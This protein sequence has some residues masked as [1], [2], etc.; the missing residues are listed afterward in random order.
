MTD[1]LSQDDLLA[2]VDRVVPETYLQPIKDVGPGYE[3]YQ[4]SAAVGARCS[5]AVQRFYEDGDI[6]MSH[7]GVLATVPVTFFR[8]DFSAGAVRVLAGTVVSCS[9]GG[10][11]FITQTDAVLGATDLEAP[12]VLARATGFGYEYN[13]RGPFAVASRDPLGPKT[14]P[15]L[16]SVTNLQ[17]F[18]PSVADRI[19]F[20]TP[21]GLKKGDTL[22]VV[23]GTQAGVAPTVTTQQWDTV[24]S[25]IGDDSD[26]VVI[27]TYQVSGT[28]DS[29]LTIDFN[30]DM[31]SA[32]LVACVLVYRNAQP[33][34]AGDVAV[35]PTSGPAP[36]FAVPGRT[37]EAV[38]DLY[39]GVGHDI[40][41][42]DT[43]VGV[44]GTTLYSQQATSSALCVFHIGAT[45]TSAIPDQTLVM[46]TGT[47]AVSTFSLMLRGVGQAAPGQIDTI[48]MPLMDPVFGDPSIQARND[49]D[50]DGLGRPRTL[51]LIGRERDIE[52]QQNE[53]DQNYRA[54][55]MTLPDTIT[56][57]AIKRQIANYARQI[58]G[59]YWRHVETWD[60][61]YQECFDAPEVPSPPGVGYDPTMFVPDD[62]R[63][64]SPIR[65]RY[66]GNNDYLG[67]FIVEIDEPPHIAEYGFALD[68]PADTLADVTSSVGVRAF[69]AFD[70]PDTLAPP[71]LVPSFDGRDY[72]A[73]KFLS[74]LFALLESI[75]AGGVFV[76]IHL[77]EH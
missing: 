24:A 76:V 20:D 30:Q 55:I 7:G 66:L 37:P 12:P 33:P 28:E 57:A 15:T 56:P 26:S 31:N 2:V 38:G 47:G 73:L 45:S 21:A 18:I 25:F 34:R 5:L 59:L 48:D 6:L 68:D 22:I 10:Q 8:T 75:K 64:P 50:S 70:V 40:D 1:Q 19:T 43:F 17:S 71:A 58:P 54:R 11:S 74:G 44:P 77:M 16:L 3:L 32:E 42:I 27:A 49:F 29:T 62:P 53:S 4:G 65:N 63:P 69:S 13:I 72:G 9:A 23:A 46:D 14:P 67:A 39:I 35:F 36:S 61:S 41:N 51:D 52:R 60:R